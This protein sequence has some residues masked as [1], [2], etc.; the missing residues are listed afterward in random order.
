MRLS[1]QEGGKVALA[2][3]GILVA[4]G[5]SW[6]GIVASDARAGGHGPDVTIVKQTRSVEGPGLLSTNVVCEKG[7]RAIGGGHA[8]RG[9]HD[10]RS[11]VAFPV[12]APGSASDAP[13]AVQDAW[14]FVVVNPTRQKIDVEVY[15]ICAPAD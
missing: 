10:P 5:L 3:A 1:G 14:D 9:A 8:F 2:G 12:S 4:V 15:A 7:R 6:G 13:G 11:P